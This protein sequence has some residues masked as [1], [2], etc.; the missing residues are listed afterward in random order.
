MTEKETV[1]IWGATWDDWDHKLLVAS[2]EGVR[3]PKQVRLDKRLGGEE[4]RVFGWQ[5]QFDADRIHYTRKDALVALF[6]R[7]KRKHD[8]AAAEFEETGEQLAIIG[9]A[10]EEES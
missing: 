8:D 2:A 10:L 9:K 5:R 4:A 7:V 6:A 3:T 1:T